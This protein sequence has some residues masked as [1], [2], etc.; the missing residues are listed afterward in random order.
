MI[1][2]PCESLTGL[3]VGIYTADEIVR[4]LPFFFYGKSLKEEH[5]GYPQEGK[6]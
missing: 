2:I 4:V 5:G 1:L 3:L 6:R